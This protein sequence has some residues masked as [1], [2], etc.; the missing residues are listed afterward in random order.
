MNPI[1]VTKTIKNHPVQF[2][3][4]VVRGFIQGQ[5]AACIRYQIDGGSWM[6]ADRLLPDQSA[7]KFYGTQQVAG[8]KI[9]GVSL[10]PVEYAALASDIEA[11]NTAIAAETQAHAEAIRTGGESITVQ[12]DDGEYLSGYT[13]YD[14]IARQ[15]L[16]RLGAAKDVDGWGTLIDS[17]LID[18]LGTTFTI[19][20]VETFTAPAR[21]AVAQ[22]EAAKK[23]ERQTK[24]TEAQA[25][26]QPVL[27]RHWTVSCDGTEL[28]C[29]VDLIEEYA[30]PDGSV[31]TQ[32]IHTY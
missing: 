8:M 14:D 29:S 19:P 23:A 20:Q 31:R 10:P 2:S 28:D 18:A 27:L 7:V 3:F 1:S 9:G 30:Y 13:V 24:I 25:T 11:I 17:R 15:E 5:D 26:G 6:N 32:R 21:E 4:E 22:A 12:W 16:I